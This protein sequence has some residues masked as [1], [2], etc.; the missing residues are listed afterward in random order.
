MEI[1][2]LYS[3]SEVAEIIGYTTK[4]VQNYMSDGR[5]KTVKVLGSNRVRESDLKDLIKDR[6]ES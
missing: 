2:K 6:E 4:T 5:I 1:E 3:A